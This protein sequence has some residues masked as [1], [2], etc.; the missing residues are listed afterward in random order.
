MLKLLRHCA[1]TLNWKAGLIVVGLV[2]V[3]FLAADKWLHLGILAGA[4]PVLLVLACL[5]PCLI[6][7]A[8]LRRKL[9]TALKE[10]APS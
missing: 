9:A 6:P 1:P 2:V 8:L 10:E 7:F 4:T 5:L 3:A